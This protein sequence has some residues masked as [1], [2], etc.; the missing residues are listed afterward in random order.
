MDCDEKLTNS[1]YAN[2]GGLCCYVCVVEG[3]NITAG[4]VELSWDAGFPS[5]Y[6]GSNITLTESDI[7]Y[8]CGYCYLPIEDSPLYALAEG[9]RVL[10]LNNGTDLKLVSHETPPKSCGQRGYMLIDPRATEFPGGKGVPWISETVVDDCTECDLVDSVYDNTLLI[11]VARGTNASPGYAF[12]NLKSFLIGGVI[13]IVRPYI[14]PVYGDYSNEA[15]LR[16]LYRDADGRRYLISGTNGYYAA[17]PITTGK[18]DIRIKTQSPRHYGKDD[19]ISSIETTLDDSYVYINGATDATVR[20]LYGEQLGERSV[21]NTDTQY[22][23]IG[24]NLTAY[25]VR[26]RKLLTCA[27]SIVSKDLIYPSSWSSVDFVYGT[28]DCTQSIVVSGTYTD[29]LG[30][31]CGGYPAG[32]DGTVTSTYTAD[33]DGLTITVAKNDTSSITV[34]IGGEVEIIDSWT[35]NDLIY[36]ESDN[37]IIADRK[38]T[39]NEYNK[40]YYDGA[41][42]GEMSNE[43]DIEGYRGSY[44]GDHTYKRIIFLYVSLTD[45]LLIYIN[46]EQNLSDDGVSFTW[47]VDSSLN[48]YFDGVITGLDTHSSSGVAGSGAI[49]GDKV[50]FRYDRDDV[51]WDVAGETGWSE[52]IVN[53]STSSVVA[54]CGVTDVIK[55]TKDETYNYELSLDDYIAGHLAF[56]GV[57]GDVAPSGRFVLPFLFSEF[58]PYYFEF[59]YDHICYNLPFYFRYWSTIGV[60]IITSLVDYTISDTRDQIYIKLRDLDGNKDIDIYIKNGVVD[61][62]GLNTIMTAANLTGTNVTLSPGTV[63]K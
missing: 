25:Q 21:L 34:D 43:I 33:I 6:G 55:Y 47:T 19:V 26:G 11:D 51:F 9:D 3:I 15:W 12:E 22:P 17:N 38:I 42:I 52:N 45:N 10:V 37:P 46:Q 13:N 27:G 57:L 35:G 40:Y 41:Y 49:L 61:L 44:P 28:Q 18:T 59:R 20:S 24:S 31:P 29:G 53:N 54:T 1:D 62:D 63:R 2:A 58:P 8:N 23:I 48:M 30:S 56:K 5:D 39:I 60:P 16:V 7:F 32:Y 50:T 36:F 4:A 14:Y